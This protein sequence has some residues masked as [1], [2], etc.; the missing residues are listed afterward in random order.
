MLVGADD[1][2]M[3]LTAMRHV[4]SLKHALLAWRDIRLRAQGSGQPETDDLIRCRIEAVSFI[5]AAKFVYLRCER[6]NMHGPNNY[7]TA[8][9]RFADAVVEQILKA[10]P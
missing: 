10:E 2:T 6:I 5:E 4:S 1:I 9:T 3:T 8:W 7:S